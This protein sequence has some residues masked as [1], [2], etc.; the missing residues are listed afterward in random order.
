MEYCAFELHP[1]IAAEGEPLPERF[2]SGRS[3][4]TQLADEAG[5]PYAKRTHRYNSTLAHEATEWAKENGAEEPYRWALYKA[6]FVDNT[7]I[8]SPDVLGDIANGLELATGDLLAA[9]DEGRYRDRVQEQYDRARQV[10][11]TAVPTFVAEDRLA[12]VGAHP[13]ENFHRLMA[14]VGAERRSPS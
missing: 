1:G 5:L 8:G 12:L 6:Y 13:Y 2:T 9:L 14:Q 7:N 10:G 3:G 11:V 4:F